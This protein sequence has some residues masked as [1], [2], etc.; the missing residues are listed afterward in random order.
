MAT[1]AG[2]AHRSWLFSIF[3]IIAVRTLQ[4]IPELKASKWT[5]VDALLTIV[6]GLACVYLSLRFHSYHLNIPAEY[7]GWVGAKVFAQS[8]YHDFS[9]K[10]SPLIFSTFHWVSSLMVS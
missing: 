10:I 1:V 3:S 8:W 4:I 9:M 7:H 2:Q 6:A 5:W